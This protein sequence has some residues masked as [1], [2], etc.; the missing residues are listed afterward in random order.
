[1][2]PELHA[3]CDCH[4]CSLM[5][6][7]PWDGPEL[8]HY[9]HRKPDVTVPNEDTYPAHVL[10]IKVTERTAPQLKPLL[11][12]FDLREGQQRAEIGA[13]LVRDCA[14]EEQS[15]SIICH[16]VDESFRPFYETGEGLPWPEWSCP[17]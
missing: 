1:M 6:I 13:W 2:N 5:S 10:A 12:A 8:W 4:A 15:D 3:P 9:F 14:N 17:I 7:M 16:F 11:R